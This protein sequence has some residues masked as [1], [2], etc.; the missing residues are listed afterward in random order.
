MSKRDHGR[1]GGRG[2]GKFGK[3]H[4]FN[5]WWTA[6]QVR[7]SQGGLKS[8]ADLRPCLVFLLAVA[9]AATLWKECV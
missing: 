9:L 6:K 7:P 5:E 1:S 4:S 2:V 8:G 3:R